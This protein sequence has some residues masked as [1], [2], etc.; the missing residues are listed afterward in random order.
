MTEMVKNLCKLFADETKL[1]GVIKSL[2]DIEGLQKDLDSLVEWSLTWLM[3]FNKT[4]ARQCTL[5]D[6]R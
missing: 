2:S 4:S 1:I 6:K 3:S 5:I